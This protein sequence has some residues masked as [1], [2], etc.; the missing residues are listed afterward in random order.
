MRPEFIH[1]RS[2]WAVPVILLVI[3]LL[4]GC[5]G[6]GGKHDMGATDQQGRNLGDATF[7]V[8]P[9][10]QDNVDFW[11]HVYGIW[12]R[13][14]VAIHDNEHM[15][16]IYEVAE[17]PGSVQAGYSPSQ[18]AWLE[19]RLGY[20]ASRLKMLEE[21]VRTG[22]TL[23]S[24]DKEL[25]AKFEN[26]GGVGALYGASDRLRA[27][28]GLR[29]RF[30]R[31]LEI[32][33]RYDAAFREIMQSHGLP[34]DLAYI[35][36]VESSFQTN[37]K[38]NVGA[39]GVWQ[40]MPATGRIYMTVNSQ[41]DERY[42]PILSADGAA[43]YLS[44]AY[45]RLG[46]WPLAITSYNHGQGGM[47]KAKSQYGNDIG[48]IVK[49][50]DGKAFGFAS[51]NYYAEFV[52]A[53]EVARN[54]QRYFPE[55]IHYEAP[56]PHD[57]L[58]LNDSM[59]VD[60]IAQHYGSSASRLAEINLHWSDAVRDGRAYLPAGSTIWLPQGSLKRVASQPPPV[61][62]KA[63]IMLASLDMAPKPKTSTPKLISPEKTGLPLLAPARINTAKT[64]TVAESKNTPTKAKSE[65]SKSREVAAKA[66]YH[67]V[68]PQ[69]TLYRVAV[70]NGLSVS[71]LRELNQMSANDNNIRPGQK[72]KVGI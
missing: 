4:N 27:Q 42:D 43:R 61:S 53:R 5:A 47:A 17:I 37:A 24:S 26:N 56:W 6:S 31:S 40:F 68:Q 50:Y 71:E 23:T 72:L 15:G 38:S 64:T 3:I 29:E 25:L 65:T 34:E 57:R 36:H 12:S 2:A 7:P 62:A 30:Q 11:R 20:H 21:R 63:P 32:S 46:S 54:P 19:S 22:Q 9:A 60:H 28:R 39:S 66:R 49:N 41:V 70:L 13:S 48:R 58:V 59:P 45:Q 35:P 69:E 44:Q 33:G 51:R 55:G 67:V 10:I 52:A 8:P 14:Q 16:V 18:Q 1:A